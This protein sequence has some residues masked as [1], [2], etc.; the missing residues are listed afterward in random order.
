MKLKNLTKSVSIIFM[1]LAMM[2]SCTQVSDD[3]T[4]EDNGNN[5]EK[6]ERIVSYKVEHYQQNANDYGYTL[7]E[8]DTENKTGTTNKNTSATAKTY[9]GFTAENVNQEK[10]MADGSTIVKIYYNRNII[11]LTLNLDGGDGDTT[12]VGK[13]GATVTAPTNPTKAG[14]TFIQWN[15]QL[16]T[17][18]PTENSIFTAKW[19]IEG[20][21]IITYNLNDGTN[22]DENP[23]SYNV[24]TE[25]ISLINPTKTG[26]KF[27][28]WYTD[29]TFNEENKITEI[30]KGST[31]DITLY[32]KWT[33]IITA[34]NVV[35]KIEAL[36]Y[37]THTIAVTGEI[38]TDTISALEAALDYRYGT[39]VNLDLSGTTGLTEIDNE[40]FSGCSMLT[41]VIIPDGVTSIGYNAF[42][43]CY[44]LGSVTIPDS[45]TFIGD[46]AFTTGCNYGLFKISENNP[47]Y[48]SS[49]DEKILFNKNQTNLIA[50]PSAKGDVTIPDSVTSIGD[51]AFYYC[52]N[53]TSITIPDSVTS[54]GSSAFERCSNLASITIGNGV[55]KIGEHV[56]SDCY[57]LTS[58]IIPDSVTYID[59]SAFEGCR[60][61]TLVLGD[62]LTSIN[63]YMPY[64]LKSITIG[65][66]VTTIKGGG[67][68]ASR[69]SFFSDSQLTSITIPDSVTE[70]GDYAFK[71]CSSL[72][73]I[74]IPD[75]V[76]YIGDYAFIGCSSLTNVTIPDSVTYIG[77]SAFM[78]CSNLTS[79]TIGNGVTE[80]GY[81]AFSGCSSL[82]SVT[83]PDS[84]TYIGECA[85]RDCSSLTS[86]TIPDS[87]TYIDDKAF[88]GC[89]NLTSITIPDS[90][91]SI[92]E[93]ALEDCNSLIYNEY[94]NG[95]YLGNADNPYLVFVK[96]KDTSIT[97]CEIN[98]KTKIILD[99]AFWECKNLTNLT[100]PDSI[101]FIGSCWGYS[102]F[103]E[104]D[105]LIYNEYGNGLYLGNADNPYVVLKQEYDLTIPSMAINNKT[106]VISVNA[107]K[108]YSQLTSITIPDSVTSI[109]DGA[110]W[111]CDGLTSITIPDSVT[112]IDDNAFN[113]CDSLTSVHITD[114]T[115]WMNIKFE[116]NR[117]NPLCNETD[118]YLNGSLVT[119]L[120]I[121]NSMTSIGK[122][123]FYGYDS[124]AS[125]TIPDSVTTIGEYAFYNCDSLTN[126]TIPDSVIS[127]G[128]SAFQYCSSLASVTIPDSVTS[129]G[130]GAFANCSSL[131]SVTIG[132]GVTEIGYDAFDGCS[133]LTS[134]TIPDSVIIIGSHAF[135]G[136]SNLTTVNYKGTQEQWGQ[137]SIGYNNSY[138]TNATINYNYTE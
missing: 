103:Y 69:Q 15:P 78:D 44:Y 95:F 63:F 137:I 120:V 138:L 23:S 101:I 124:L 121:P 134:V 81:D 90:V 18:F 8:S 35:E 10:I 54:I 98:N 7:V 86:I 74:T 87:V 136:C 127:I 99:K 5:N 33:E 108:N 49:D 89:S 62:G 41:S 48:S 38:S 40:A 128:N 50:Y 37:G 59:R 114:L 131:T 31:G 25:T 70:I 110:F 11:T 118:L 21:Y 4:N 77:S 30:T 112:Y 57:N 130:D 12:I 24:E 6:K 94:D 93:E 65:S 107:F 43:S 16:P 52:S 123:V 9:T 129:I 1:L 13:Y 53:L 109:G 47:N 14:Y 85:F 27:A 34:S 126:V 45:V 122:Y 104:C 3:T 64:G 116:N 60:V 96:A 56:F 75:S 29:E 71:C 91:T 22:A 117:S 113:N 72:T 97:S 2:F 17:A 73:S 66:S 68:D 105:S 55:T 115:A 42:S 84:V 46:G 28:G 58:V 80:I 135:Y 39:Y 26:Y 19:A 61:S 106:K 88:Y 32:A 82:T 132:N 125:V 133:S 100:I 36:T 76:T 79:V 102:P 83:I 67:V 51:Y 20:D 92:G 111:G 119:D